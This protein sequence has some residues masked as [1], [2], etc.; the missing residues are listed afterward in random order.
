MDEYS[1]A[2]AF[3][4]RR[5]DVSGD[6]CAAVRHYMRQ[7][8]S[9]TRQIL[10]STIARLNRFK[11]IPILQN[12][13][14]AMRNI[15][16]HYDRSNEFY[17]LFL[18]S[19]MVYSAAYFE[20]ADDSLEKAQE[21]KLDRIGTDLV[22]RAGERFLDIGCGWGALVCYAAEHFGTR[23]VGCTLS[24]EQLEFTR[25]MLQQRGLEEKASV[26]LRDYRDLDGCYDKIASVGMFEHVGRRLPPDYFRKIYSLLNSGGLFLNRGVVRIEGTSDSAETLFLQ[27]QVF[28]GGELVH[29]SDVVREGQRAGF[30]V[31]GARDLRLHYAL[32]C[33]RWVE[34]LRRNAVRCIALVGEATYRTW[35]LYLAASAVS[36]EDRG[37]GA[38]QVLFEKRA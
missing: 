7:P 26:S 18:G 38:A 35:L 22:L 17:S 33:R 10:F 25:N 21:Q 24:R 5:F 27:K 23:A 12:R 31:I 13:R 4:N 32:T 34:N 29:L 2:R 14:K 20:D 9:R 6:I 30:D 3:V 8:H 36:F 15:W 37:T 1:A 16:F 28:P 19:R 11:L